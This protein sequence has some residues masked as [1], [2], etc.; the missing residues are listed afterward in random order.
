MRVRACVYA[1][2]DSRCH[3]W[4][5]ERDREGETCKSGDVCPR[6]F[7]AL[8]RSRF[9]AHEMQPGTVSVENE[10]KRRS[11]LHFLS[12]A[13]LSRG[14]PR[15]RQRRDRQTACLKF[16]GWARLALKSSSCSPDAC[17]AHVLA[18]THR[19]RKSLCETRTRPWFRYVSLNCP[20]AL[21]QAHLVRAR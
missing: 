1:G 8:L 7:C 6:P 13:F 14:G 11:N 10:I 15:Y 9:G 3:V 2:V 17:T 18:V 19:V 20:R 4:R 12:S 21:C 5:P 16:Q